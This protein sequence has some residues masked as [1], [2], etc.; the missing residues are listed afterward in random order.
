MLN[1][2]KYSRINVF[3]QQTSLTDVESKTCE[4]VCVATFVRYGNNSFLFIEETLHNFLGAIQYLLPFFE[5]LLHDSRECCSLNCEG[6]N[7]PRRY[8]L[9]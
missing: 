7:D 1:M 6:S 8:Q 3:E 4:I 2:Y 5:F 9:V